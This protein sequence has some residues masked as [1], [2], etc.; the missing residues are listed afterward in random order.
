[1]LPGTRSSLAQSW[2]AALNVQVHEDLCRE[3]EIT[4]ASDRAF[5]LVFAGLFCAVTLWPLARGG[6]VNVWAA[7][8]AGVFLAVTLLRPSLLAPLNRLW[9]RLGVLL[10]SIVSPLVLAF[11]FF[12]VL[13]PTA[14]LMRA[15]GSRPLQLGFERGARTYWITRN[16]A[17]PAPETMRRQF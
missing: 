15:V 14:L 7:G 2:I 9:F 11:I 1:M 16:P 8:V 3:Q 13:V 10:H 5:G 17:G 6:E 4:G 12:A